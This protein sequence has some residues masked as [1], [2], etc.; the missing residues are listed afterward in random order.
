MKKRNVLIEI[1]LA[2]LEIGLTAYGFAILPK[3]KKVITNHGWL[4]K[5]ELDEGLAMVQLYPGPIMFNLATYGA[6][7]AG[8][9]IGAF[10]G[11]LA[12]VTPTFI[13]MM[14]LSSLYFSAGKILWVGQILMGLKA[15]VV[16]IILHVTIELGERSIRGIPE[17]AIFILSFVALLIGVNT[18]FIVLAAFIAGAL[19]IKR[20]NK[21]EDLVVKTTTPQ[22]HWGGIIGAGVVVLAGVLISLTLVPPIR[23][24]ALSFFKIGALAFGN[25][26]TILPLIQADAVNHYH[27]LTMGEFMD[28]IALGQVTPGPILITAAFIGYKLGGVWTALLATFAIFSPSF[29][30]TLIMSEIYSRIKHI[31]YIKG[32]LRGVLP[33]FVGLL[34]V[35]VLEMGKVG[36]TGFSTLLL[37]AAAFISI[38]YFKLD[39][40]WIFLGGLI[41]W[42]GAIFLGMVP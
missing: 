38:K 7:R 4:S 24:M 29:V 27:W 30:F 18:I 32:A 22:S 25:G 33:A 1:F 9:V 35:M 6:Y 31:K 34:A 8:G 42:A 15:I 16:G 20:P 14:V 41:L 11:T 19:F 2:Y 28:G 26:V 23:A 40:I 39:V 5:D 36:I 37:A 10:I 12:F 21:Q 17:G 3:L 13:L